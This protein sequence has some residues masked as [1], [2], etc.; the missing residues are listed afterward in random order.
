M[1][2][3]FAEKHA[4]LFADECDAS[5]MENKLEYTAVYQEFQEL[6][7]EKVEGNILTIGYICLALIKECG[8]SVEDFFDL[9]K[10]VLLFHHL[11]YN[12]EKRG[13]S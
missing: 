5:A 3:R 11:K 9:I 12:L 8:V 10:K 13:P 1:F 7:E 4:H 2:A 6:F